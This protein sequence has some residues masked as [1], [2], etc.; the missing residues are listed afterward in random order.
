MPF[1]YNM[2]T[3]NTKC[4]FGQ[5]TIS[6]L[7]TRAGL[8]LFRFTGSNN[9]YLQQKLQIGFLS[10]QQIIQYFICVNLSLNILKL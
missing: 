10:L 9:G 5:S 4:E 8:G 2:W 6:V 1:V 3:Q 7:D